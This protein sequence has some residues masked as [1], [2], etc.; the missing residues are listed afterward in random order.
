[1][2]GILD[3]GSKTDHFPCGD[4]IDISPRM[5]GGIGGCL[6]TESLALLIEDTRC[7]VMHV[8]ATRGNGL[9]PANQRPE[10]TWLDQSELRSIRRET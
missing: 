7:N 10:E 5:H 6:A 8:A 2:F 3:K 9:I 4:F 1:M